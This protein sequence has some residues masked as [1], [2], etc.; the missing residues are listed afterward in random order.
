M[1]IEDDDQKSAVNV[2]N[3]SSQ[4]HYSITIWYEKKDNIN[5]VLTNE[6]EFMSPFYWKKVHQLLTSSTS[7]NDSKYRIYQV[8]EDNSLSKYVE[9]DTTTEK[10]HMLKNQV[11]VILDQFMDQPV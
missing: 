9:S 7:K 2:I 3:D 1:G 4:R 10:K 6:E 8:K 5:F 11:S